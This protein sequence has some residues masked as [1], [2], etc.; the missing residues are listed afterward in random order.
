MSPEPNEAETKPVLPSS[1][2]PP[3]AFDDDWWAG[4]V[5]AQLAKLTK[6][7]TTLRYGVMAVGGIA[8][9]AVGVSAMTGKLVT[10]LMGGIQILA[11][12]QQQLGELIAPMPPQQSGAIPMPAATPTEARDER[13]MMTDVAPD[14]AY[15]PVNP[16]TMPKD[17]S[18]PDPTVDAT[19]EVAPPAE[20]P[21]GGTSQAVRDMLEADGRVSLKDDLG[22]M[23][24][25][26]GNH[27]NPE[28]KS[29]ADR[30]AG[31]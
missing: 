27:I 17:R 6:D 2:A 8:L 16:M 5:D 1:I 22:D 19:A 7:S 30:E 24:A 31:L 12:Q 21:A 29:Q 11:D 26:H 15:A 14:T 4:D 20:G 18:V 10:K 25:V 28:S 9:M 23:T 13:V 3:V